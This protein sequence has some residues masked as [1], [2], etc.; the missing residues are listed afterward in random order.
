MKIINDYIGKQIIVMTLIVA[1]ALLGVDLFFSL[2]N[3]L[4][5]IGQGNYHLA[6]AFIVTALTIPRKL[7]TMFPWSALLGTL[8]A[9]GQL[10]KA[11]EL[12]VM[13]A[14]A[15]SVHKIAW[16]TLRAV[17]VLAI[18]IFIFGEIVA[19]IFEKMA[20][21][22]K[23]KALSLGQAIQTDNGIWVRNENEFIHVGMVLL[24]GTLQQLSKYSFDKE[25][26]LQKVM[27]AN[28]AIPKNGGWLLK[29]I[30]GTQFFQDKTVQI[31]EDELFLKN[32]LSREILEVSGVKH[33]ERLSLRY[34][35]KV[36]QHRAKHG[37]NVQNYA[38]AFWTKIFQPFS[39]LVM[40]YLVIPFVFGPLRS[41]SVGLRLLVGIAIGFSF[42]VINS[43]AAQLPTVINFP[44]ILALA[45]SPLI[46][47]VGG[48]IMMTRVR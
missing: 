14:A 28:V 46:F 35:H 36:I 43:I 4:K 40:V 5:F 7:Y 3:E 48:I 45:I 26:G 25:L 34:L 27:Y 29:N 42:Y 19:P 37:L 9:L 44:P 22:E 39:I 1:L 12:I 38:I 33:L 2:V 15:I 11:S 20:Q 23:V 17:L 41:S 31:N 10:A 47:G 6:T 8:L 32:L 13:R 16:A 21:Q 30:K 24:D 18:I